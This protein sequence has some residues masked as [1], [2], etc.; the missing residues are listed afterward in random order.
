MILEWLL[1]PVDPARAH[2][3]GL[4]LSW[5]ARIMVLGWGILA[6]LAILTARYLKVLPGQNWPGELDN[7]M[8]WRC[9]WMGQS[10]VLVLSAAGVVMI[11][12][13]DQNTGHEQV[14]RLF[15]Y[16]LLALG[17]FQALS[18]L[19][20]GTK[21][22]PTSPAPDG[23]FRGDHYDMTPRRH[24]F[25]SFHKLFGY[26]ALVMM[27]GAIGTG[28]WATNA[29]RWMWL[30]LLV[31]WIGL[32]AAAVVLQRKGWAVDT[33]QAIWG[34]DPVHPGNRAEKPAHA[35]RAAI[36]SKKRDM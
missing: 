26:L 24:F 34:P 9:H 14:H 5:H 12:L 35:A 20:R 30:V 19:L 7:K 3:V 33:Y 13:S 10:T 27:T 21:G 4:A 36:Y 6:P 31:W 28:L 23:S 1:S 16:C 32:T 18:G 2:D 11:L 25:E 29:P 22:G 15:G 17:G 8:W